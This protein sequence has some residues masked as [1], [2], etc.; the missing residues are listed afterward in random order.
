MIYCKTHDICELFESKYAQT[1]P[2][3]QI[4]TVAAVCR[5]DLLFE[6]EATACVPAQPPRL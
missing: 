4:T 5:D 2:W 6:I 1:L 3:P